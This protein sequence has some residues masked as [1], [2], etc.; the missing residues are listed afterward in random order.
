VD[1]APVQLDARAVLYAIISVGALLAAESAGNET[2]ADT[3]GALALTLVVLWLA[4][5]YSEFTAQRLA[6]KKPLSFDALARAL[7]RELMNVA[8][9]AIPLLALLICWV[10]KVPLASAVTA[11]LWT[12][13]AMIVTVE[14]VAGVRAELSAGA[15]VAQTAVGALFGLLMI[16]L[17]LILH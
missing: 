3:A 17:K 12:A 14:V 5:A 2:Y 16:A 13:A 10:A 4:H 15:L 8:V 9:A 11:A 6:E 1:N 7:V